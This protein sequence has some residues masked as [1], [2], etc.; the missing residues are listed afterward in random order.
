MDTKP[1]VTILG[2]AAAD[3]VEAAVQK[4]PQ[5]DRCWF[6]RPLA[7]DSVLFGLEQFVLVV[8]QGWRMHPE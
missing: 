5:F 6:V 4:C 8:R 1:R 3:D 7:V 2:T